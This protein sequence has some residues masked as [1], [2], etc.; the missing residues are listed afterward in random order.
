MSFG[1]RFFLVRNTGEWW[2]DETLTGSISSWLYVFPQL[3]GNGHWRRGFNGRMSDSE[4]I[5]RRNPSPYSRMLSSTTSSIRDGFLALADSYPSFGMAG[6]FQFGQ[7]EF[8][9]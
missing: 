9:A 6:L 2:K 4:K 7:G 1:M 8:D 3:S 5:R